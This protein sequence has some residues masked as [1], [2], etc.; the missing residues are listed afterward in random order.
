MDYQV[1]SKKTDYIVR[2][3]TFDIAQTELLK[4]L[5]NIHV[6]GVKGYRIRRG[7][8]YKNRQTVEFEK[9]NYI[10]RF[11]NVPVK[12][13]TFDEDIARMELRPVEGGE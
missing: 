11:T 8:T 9:D 1:I 2:S 5:W 3:A 6:A 12:C 10:H 7:R 4:I 13:G